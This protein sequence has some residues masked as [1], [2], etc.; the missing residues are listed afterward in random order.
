M[1]KRSDIKVEEA[2]THAQG[3]AGR[4]Y[5]GDKIKSASR[6]ILQP[7]ITKPVCRTE[8]SLE[9]K[10]A[11]KLNKRSKKD[12]RCLWDALAPGIVVTRTS[13]TSTTLR[14]PGVPEVRLRTNDFVRFGSDLLR[15]S[16][17]WH[18]A[19]RRPF[20]TRKQQEEI[21]AQHTC[22]TRMKLRT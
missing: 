13:P 5:N 12:L 22:R 8:N 11:R 20:L 19:Q 10:L 17:L 1:A 3:E 15:N 18:Y 6:F 16:P 21:F 14:E 2:M 9:L 4:R 7:K